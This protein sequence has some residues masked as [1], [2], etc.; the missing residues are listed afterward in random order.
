MIEFNGIFFNSHPTG[1]H[2]LKEVETSNW[3]FWKKKELKR[4]FTLTRIFKMEFEFKGFK[5]NIDILPNFEYDGSSIPKI[6]WSLIG[7]PFTGM[8]LEAATFHDAWY[9]CKCKFG[10]KLGDEIFKYIM[11]QM[12]VSFLKS[13]I[14]HKGVRLG[15]SKAWDSPIDSENAKFVKIERVKIV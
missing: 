15:G 14:K 8:Y 6:V 2:N 5:Y 9:V 13:N 11:D 4:Q 12:D 3:F 1:E 7:S 10:R